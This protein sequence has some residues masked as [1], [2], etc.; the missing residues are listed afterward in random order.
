MRNS[1]SARTTLHRL[2]GGCIVLIGLIALAS[3]AAAQITGSIYGTVSDESNA[4]LPGVSVTVTNPQ[5]NESHTTATNAEGMFTFAQLTVGTYNV[6]AELTG[7]KA[8]TRAGIE[9]TLNR[10]ARVDFTLAIGEVVEEMTVI[11]D[12]PLVESRSNEMGTSVS[13]RQV[14]NLP[15]PD[16]NPLRLVGL[17]PGAG[18]VLQSDNVQGF[19]SNRVAFNGA[20]PELSNWLLDGGDNTATLRNYGN[21]S[22]NP[23]AVQEFRVISNNYSAEFGRS[24]GAIVNVVTKSGTNAFRGSAFEF[25]RDDSM[26]KRNFFA[27]KPTDYRR[28]QS[29]GTLGGPMRKNQ[30]FFFA[31][32]QGVRERRERLG[33][34]VV[35]PTADQRRGIF[36]TPIRDPL[37]GQNFPNNTIPA[38]LIVRPALEFLNRVIPLPNEGTD[39]YRRTFVENAPE[40]QY[41]AKIDHLISARHKLSVAYFRYASSLVENTTNIEYALRDTATKQYNANI[42]EWWTIGPALL[43]HFHINYTRS[44]G[45]RDISTSGGFTV[46]DLGVNFGPLA[47]LVI[48]PGINVSGSFGNLGAAAGGPKFSNNYML[49]D[50]LDWQKGRHSIKIGGELWRRR[51]F[52]YTQGADNGGA[53]TFSGAATGNGL[54]DFLLGRVQSFSFRAQTY[55]VNDQW[56]SYGFAQDNFRASDRLTVNLGLRYELDRYPTHPDGL[57]AVY[58]PGQK[59]ACVPNA[60]VGEL[61]VFCDGDNL[62]R[63]GYENDTNNFQPRLGFAYSLTSDART[64][65]RGGYGLA[66]AFAIFNTLQEGQVALPFAIRQTV[67]STTGAIDFLNPFASVPGGN[68]FPYTFNPAAVTFPRSAEYSLATLDMPTGSVHQFNLSFQRQFGANVA[69]ELAY[70]GSRGYDLAGFYNINAPHRQAD[71]TLAPRP[72][73]TVPFTTVTIFRGDVRTWYDSL[74]ARLEKRFSDG[75]SILGSY[76]LGKSSD[77]VSFHSDQTWIDPQH[78]E[79]NK[80][81]SDWDR[82]HA[83]ALSFVW[84]LPFARGRTGVTGSVLGGWTLSGIAQY[85][86]GQPVDILQSGDPN[87]DTLG[88]DRPTLVGDWAKDRPSNDDIKAGATWFNVDALRRLASGQNGNFGRNVIS[89]PGFKNV[90]VSLSKRIRIHD[91]DG[92]EVRIESFNLLNFV[93]F[94]APNSDPANSLYG[95]IT[96]AGAG[97]S[98]QLAARYSF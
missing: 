10:N 41:M 40:D 25:F 85:Q 76:T 79:L 87:G 84:E 81:R 80:G 97:R 37:T 95:K 89:G 11:G 86:T 2:F 7:F 57:I 32:Y 75:F 4:V 9:L 30:T 16:R 51:Q 15:T 69:G 18:Q 70:V 34:V 63:G 46:N 77:Y 66:N 67:T 59:S 3:P 13:Q 24:V 5:T 44:H 93:N 17:L 62:P 28:H 38:N 54:A 82:R 50:T 53:F 91:R 21:P 72:L 8:I 88:N 71:G 92:V 64:V 23:D 96:A 35:V 26:N 45:T 27:V 58:V 98:F 36:T 68:P 61:F 20:R 65:L 55:K 31:T 83:A 43:N 78:P 6:R 39:R 74:Q 49:R 56:A 42:Q 94:S 14:E 29:G 60:P 22:P 90:D 52:D 12:A 19:Q 48:G 1:V 47:D 73:G 33:G